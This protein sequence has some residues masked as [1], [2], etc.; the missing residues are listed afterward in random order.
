MFQLLVGYPHLEINK[1]PFESKETSSTQTEYNQNITVYITKTGVKYHRE[2]CRYLN[3]SKISVS[4]DKL[5][6][7]TY[8]ACSVCNPMVLPRKGD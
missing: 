3:Q 1:I 6:T 8:S 4:L 5:N 2:N 7:H